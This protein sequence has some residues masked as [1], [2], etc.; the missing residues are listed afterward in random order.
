[1]ARGLSHRA[2]VLALYG[3]AIVLA[4]VA[5]ALFHS[6]AEQTLAYGGALVAIAV[7]LLFSAGYVRFDQTRKLLSDRKNNLA[8]RAAVRQAG[9]QLRRAE[10]P[11]AIWAVVQETLPAL[12]ASCA[13]LTLVARNGTIKKLEYSVGFDEAPVEVLRARFSLLGERPDDGRIELGFVDGRRT[14]DRDTE[15]A[16]ELLCEHVHAA[17]ERMA[18]QHEAEETGSRKLLRLRR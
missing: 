8:M 17:I 16:V 1:M 9:E 12:Q 6:D 5:L 10:E 4:G 3:I 15:I 18:A 14:V 11:D 2:T 7:M 13:S